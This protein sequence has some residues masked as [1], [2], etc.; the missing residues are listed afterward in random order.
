MTDTRTSSHTLSTEHEERQISRLLNGLSAMAILF[1][2][3]IGTKAWYADHVLHAWVLWLFTIPIIINIG[4]YA[5]SGNQTVQKT[6][7]LIIVGLLFTYLI[8][9]GGEGNTGPLWF[10]VFPPLLFY[11][12]SLK[13]GTAILLF[14]YLLAIL[15]FQFPDLPG[16]TAEYSS[17]FKIRFF[18]TL[19]FE[20]IFCFVL[21]AGRLQARNKLVALAQAHEHAARTDELTGLANRRDMQSRL[22]TEFSRYE[23]S[24]HHFSVVLIDLDLFKRIND[25]FGHDAGD[26]VLR[27]FARLTQQLIRQ[28]DV[29]ARWGG[30]EFLLL[31]PDTTL[32][33]ALTLAERLRAEVAAYPFLHRHQSLPVTISAGVCSI[34]TSGSVNELLRQADVQLYN[35]KENGRNRIA[36]RVRSQ[37]IAPDPGS[38][39]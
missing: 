22:N 7:L 16:V 10:Y 38:P 19:T 23:R 28:S 29:A 35:A 12:T 21:E 4:W 17:D 6:G 11:V 13:G 8:A 36:P 32:L 9:S 24:G 31:L 39:A 37:T 27:Q 34:S 30:E 3:G 25:E 14:C 2:T 18:A 33:Q 1:L 15:V 26:E 20:S 5:W